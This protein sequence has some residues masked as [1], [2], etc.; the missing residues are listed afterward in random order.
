MPAREGHGGGVDPRFLL[1]R[2]ARHERDPWSG[3]MALPGGRRDPADASL[4]ATAI[5]ETREETRVDLSAAGR[6]LGRL[7]TVTPRTPHLPAL[8]VIPFVFVLSGPVTATAASPEV[9]E[10]VWA[11]VTLL[12]GDNARITHYLPMEGVRLAFPALDVDGRTVWGLTHRILDD[13]RVRMGWSG[14]R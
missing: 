9:A 7:P 1:I 3:Q 14:V 10:V 13:F 5:R 2:R 11:P 4:L 8:S 12:V 6:L